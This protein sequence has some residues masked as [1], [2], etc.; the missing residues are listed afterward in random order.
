MSGSQLRREAL[1]DVLATRIPVLD[2][3]MATEM[4]R[5]KVHAHHFGGAQDDGCKEN[6]VRPW[7]EV[8]LKVRRGD[9]TSGSGLISGGADILLIEIFPDVLGVEVALRGRERLAG[10]RTSEIGADQTED[11]M[12][13][14]A[15]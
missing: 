1:Y 2:R 5:C 9:L 13:A 4:H 10:V 12:E 11:M 6:P 15:V 3:A 8:V 14:V 7:P